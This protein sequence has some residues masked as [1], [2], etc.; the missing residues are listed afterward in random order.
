M[1]AET[2][3][4]LARRASEPGYDPRHAVLDVTAELAAAESDA[5]QLPPRLRD[6]FLALLAEVRSVQP[7]YPS[8]RETSPLFDRA[9][10]GQPARER[11]ERLVRRLV[12]LAAAVERIGKAR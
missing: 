2:L 8:R 6:E 9:G 11:A 1:P 5:A 10:L 3:A 12:S 7:D 4:R